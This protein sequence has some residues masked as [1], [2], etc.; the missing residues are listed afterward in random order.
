[1][2]SARHCLWQSHSL[3][4]PNPCCFWALYIGKLSTWCTLHVWGSFWPWKTLDKPIANMVC[5]DDGVDE[6]RKGGDGDSFATL[7][8]IVLAICWEESPLDTVFSGHPQLAPLDILGNPW[9]TH[10]L[11]W[12]WWWLWWS[13]VAVMKIVMKWVV[14]LIVMTMIMIYLIC[15]YLVCW[16]NFLMTDNCNGFFNK[17]CGTDRK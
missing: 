3:D 16:G 5:V 8:T 12:W 17:Q 2:W 1:M 13:V 10:Q 11:Q 4:L 7:A 14:I 9:T 6:W 15:K